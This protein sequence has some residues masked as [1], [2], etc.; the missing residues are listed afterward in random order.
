MS[1]GNPNRQSPSNVWSG[2]AIKSLFDEENGFVD[3]RIYTDQD[4]YDMEQEMIFGRSWLLLGHET[5]VRKAGDFL[6]TYMGEDPV[7]MVRQKDGSIKVFLNQCR[8]R[9]MKLC[10]EDHGNAKNFTCSYH[11][12]AHDIAGNLISVPF[13]ERA[14]GKVLD[15]TE[16]GPRQARV[17]TYKGLVFANW[18]ATAPSLH[19]WMSDAAPYLDHMLDRSDAGTEVIGGIQKWVIPCNW[20]FA[21]EQFTCDFYHAGTVSHLAGITAGL[22]E[23]VELGDIELPTEGVQFRSEW[24]GHGT[25]FMLRNAAILQAVMGPEVTKYWTDSP[26]AEVAKRRLGGADHATYPV[27]N[28][29]TVFPTMSCLPGINT[30]RTWQ[31]RGPHETEIWVF[32]LV[33]SD[34]PAEIKEEY[35]RQNVRTFSSGGVFEQDDG[36]NWVE[37]QRVLRGHQARNTVLNVQMGMGNT[38]T[39]HPVYHGKIGYVYAEEAARGFYH[40][41]QRMLTETDW[42]TL[43]PQDYREAAE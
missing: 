41:W 42:A 19:E 5:H 16:W 40:H 22:P 27:G 14:F 33:D 2:T 15:K 39:D 24:G 34:A 6:A 11:G 7:I 12:W 13:E 35:R 30:V 38:R 10:R 25:G 43:A 28:H 21:A 36:E 1:C 17:E 29:M 37:I 20:K 9:S 32:T 31:P 4:I 23:D 26:A 8:H 18:D 3:P